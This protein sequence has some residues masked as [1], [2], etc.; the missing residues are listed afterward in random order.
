MASGIDA[1]RRTINGCSAGA[2][3]AAE[4]GAMVS[5]H[6]GRPWRFNR[7]DPRQ[8]SLICA[9]PA[10]H[11]LIVRRVASIPLAI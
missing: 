9:A 3:I 1:T 6:H 4:A 11:P 7:P 5:D 2:L 8:P 10:L